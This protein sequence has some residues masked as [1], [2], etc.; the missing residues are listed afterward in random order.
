MPH[1]TDGF[2]SFHGSA[3]QVEEFIRNSRS[4][5]S[6]PGEV[7]ARPAFELKPGDE[8]PDGTVFAGISPDT[9]RAMYAMPADAPLTCTFNQAQKYAAKLDAL[10]HQDWHVPT[11]GELNVLYNNRAAVGGFKEAWAA[12]ANCYWSS[13]PNSVNDGWVQ[14]FSDGL[15]SNTYNASS[16]RCVRG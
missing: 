5:L 11:K 9:G 1:V 13:S 8:M 15:Q 14:R 4:D 2:N 3:A 16:L 7:Q 6:H 10:G 12:P